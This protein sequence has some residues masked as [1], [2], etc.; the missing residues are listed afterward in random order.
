WD[1][2]ESPGTDEV[3]YGGAKYGGKSWFLCVWSYLRACAFAKK[4]KIPKSSHPLKVGF[5]GRKVAKMFRETTLDTWFKTIP[6]DGY[7]AKGNPTEIIIDDRVKILTGGFDNRE[8][9]NKFNSAEFA[10]FAV[11]QAEELTRDEMALLRLAT[12]G[13]LVVNEKAIP[14]KGLLTANP[15]HCWLKDEFILNPIKQRKFVSALP[16]DNPYCTQKYIDN[17]I[18]S[19]KHRPKLLAAYRYGNWDVLEDAEQVIMDSWLESA[20]NR[21][22]EYWPFVKEYIAI[23]CARF[24]DDE[25]VILLMNNTDIKEKIVMPYCRT[26]EISGRAAALSHQNNDCELVV[27]SIGSDLGAGVVDELTELGHSVLVYTPQGKSSEP[28]KYYNCRAEAWSKTAKVLCS[29]VIDED[30]NCFVALTKRGEGDNYGLD[31]TMRG[32][33]CTPHYKWVRGKIVIEPKEDIK[34]KLGRSPDHADAYVIAVWAWPFI[35]MPNKSGSVRHRK[36][37]KSPM[38]M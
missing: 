13:R 4:H 14:G 2:L 19:L 28:D 38:S 3:L 32:Q 22:G 9:V 30:S 11:D 24:G 26:T 10:F 37:Q 21:H 36:R 29:G 18:D 35:S 33:L 8:L 17:L 12:F 6:A 27:E 31:D 5:L 15:R 23:D 16:T 20:L 25:T 34:D 1:F 7:V